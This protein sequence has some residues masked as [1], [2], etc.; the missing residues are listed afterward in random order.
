MTQRRIYQN[1][2]PYFITFRTR[3]GWPVFEDEKMAGLMADIMSNAGRL[4]RFDIVAYQ[5]MPDHVHLLT[6][7]NRNTG[8][9]DLLWDRT[10]E[11]VRSGGGD[12]VFSSKNERTLSN[13]R[14]VHPH[15]ISDLVQSC[16]GNFSREIHIGN[17]WQR[18]FYA[19]IVSTR[20]YLE[21]VIMYIRCNPVKACLPKKY[22][23]QPYQY[24]NFN[25][26]NNL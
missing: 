15:T 8:C 16:K 19:R 18:R 9:G 21:T 14:S 2:Y 10:L 13:V 24:F 3:E 1:E 23:N 11:R 12:N 4:K 22:A 25:K 17:I 20:K 7:Y 6:Q 26:L 5:I